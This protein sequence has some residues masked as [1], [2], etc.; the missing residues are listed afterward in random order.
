MMPKIFVIICP[1]SGEKLMPTKVWSSSLPNGQEV[2]YGQFGPHHHRGQECEW[3]FLV[4]PVRQ[5]KE[6]L[7]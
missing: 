1:V 5:L 7:F 6:P 3:S 2:Q 4:Q